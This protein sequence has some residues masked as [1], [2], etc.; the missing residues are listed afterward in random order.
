MG[1]KMDEKMVF[2]HWKTSNSFSAK[3]QLFKKVDDNRGFRLKIDFKSSRYK[4]PARFYFFCG[5]LEKFAVLKMHLKN[6]FRIRFFGN[7]EKYF[8]AMS[9]FFKA[10]TQVK[11]FKI[12]NICYA[13]IIIPMVYFQNAK[14]SIRASHGG[15]HSFFS[16]CTGGTGG[17]GG[18]QRRL[19]CRLSACAASRVLNTAR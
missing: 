7:I 4:Y 9:V 15:H 12:V 11:A 13:C 18:I 3:T 17:T 10:R 6:S 2:S 16:K 1:E 8:W 5:Y 19:W 14:K